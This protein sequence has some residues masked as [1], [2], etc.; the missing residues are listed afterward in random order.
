MRI[1]VIVPY[2]P[3]Y[4]DSIAELEKRA[5]PVGAY[6]KQMLRRV[7]NDPKSFS[8]VLLDGDKVVGYVSAI[9]LDESSADIESIAVDP[10]Y[11]GQG[12]GRELMK[13]IEEEMKKRGFSVSVLEVRD[14]NEKALKFYLSNGYRIV[15]HIPSYYHEYYEGSRG[16]YR[17]AKNLV[18]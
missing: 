11:Q 2:S 9:P 5:F 10:N 17:M 1:A 14:K 16:A 6:S 4:L 15:K 7:F 8:F 12:Y 13:I 3:Q 18:T